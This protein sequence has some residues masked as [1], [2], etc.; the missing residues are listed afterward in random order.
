MGRL[1]KGDTETNFEVR[2]FDAAISR[3]EYDKL[4]KN[5][6]YIIL[7]NLRSAFNVGSIFRLCDAMRV[8]GLFLCGYTAAPP[9]KKLL[10]TS[11]GTIDYVPWKHFESAVDAV[12]YLKE[13]SIPVWAAETTSLSH[14]YLKAAYPSPL[15]VVFGNEALG[16]SSEVLKMCDRLIEIPLFGYKNSINVAASCAVVGFR[17]IEGMAVHTKTTVK[18]AE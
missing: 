16:V 6:L 8:S 14:S 12:T 1:K 13:R 5:P 9:N 3:K 10:K 15:G 17:I 7:D 11:L 4:P 18:I 2:S